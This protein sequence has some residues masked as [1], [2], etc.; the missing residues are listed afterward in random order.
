MTT[1]DS[2]RYW[3]MAR[4]A[5]T[6]EFD[7]A[8]AGFDALL[9]PATRTAAPVVADIDQSTTAAIFTRP[10]NLIRAHRMRL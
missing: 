2:R 4:A 3:L 10:I 9:T 5:I 8:L 7:E 6:R 1:V